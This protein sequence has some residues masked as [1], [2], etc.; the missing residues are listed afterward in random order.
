MSV[1]HIARLTMKEAARKRLLLLVLIGSVLFLALFGLGLWLLHREVQQGGI[2][3]PP[4]QAAAMFAVVMTIMGFYAL[5]FLAGLSAIFTS[6]NAISGEIDSGTIHA[7]LARPL[8]RRDI[9]LGKWLGYA[10]VMVL[11]VVGMS[12]GLFAIVFLVTDVP[13]AAPL[14]VMGLLVL[15]ALL[16]LTLSI[17][18]G[19]F[20][21][22]LANGIGLFLLYGLGWL[23][24]LIEVIGEALENDTMQQL[25]II[26]SLIIPSDALWRAASFYLIPPSFLLMQ[27][28]ANGPISMPF[29]STLP[30]APAMIV[31][32]VLYA[33]GALGLAVAIFR[34]RD[35]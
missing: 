13:P 26:V 33:L 35:L 27:G 6:V 11:Y 19:T 31:F 4:Q 9:V 2:Q 29:I 20:L 14:A 28:A 22:T 24:G 21:P 17:L 12:A 5:N 15:M 32:S 1:I 25:G 8:R 23:G 10:T 18:G 3:G 34:R 16:L 30:P 7:L